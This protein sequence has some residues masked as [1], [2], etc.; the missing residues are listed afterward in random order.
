MVKSIRRYTEKSERERALRL[1]RMTY[2]ESAAVLER[3]LRSRLALELHF[4]K[5]DHPISFGKRLLRRS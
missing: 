3:L 2:R 4:S 5:D 1:Q